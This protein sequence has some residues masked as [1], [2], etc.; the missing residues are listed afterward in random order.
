MLQEIVDPPPLESDTAQHAQW[1][2]VRRLLA[3]ADGPR[4]AR[5]LADWALQIR[6][7]V[8][9]MIDH[10]QQG[11][12]GGDFSAADILASLFLGVLNIRPDDPNWPER[13]RMIVSKGHS[14]AS[15]YSAL[16]L[17]GFFAPERLSTYM[18]P[19]SPFNGHPNRN[20]VPGVETNTGALGHGLPVG[21]GVA[22]GG[23]IAG[24][25]F[26]TFVL[27]GDGEL[28]EGSNWE[29]LMTGAR[30][31][32]DRLT[33]IVDRNRLQQGARTEET[34]ALDPL[35]AKLSSFG[36]EV[37]AVD[38]HDHAAVLEGV[39]PSTTG[40]PVAVIANT[41]KGHGVSFIEDRVEW[42]HRVPSP[43]QVEAALAEL[44]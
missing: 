16:A 29:A 6:R 4:R 13:D 36:W 11:H 38:G 31:A 15:L 27:T 24:R 35:D 17:C 10:A 41:T 18:D 12:I 2:E 43:E 32:L 34:T 19:L 30:Y 1:L 21:V 8:V 3:A 9:R 44:A 5:M 7:S 39:R 26:R 25:A 20:S 22:L 42:H 14:S 33:L 23:K 28:Q 37:R 40:G